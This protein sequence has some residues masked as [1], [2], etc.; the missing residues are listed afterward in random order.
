MLKLCTKVSL[1]TNFGFL[2]HTQNPIRSPL[3]IQK[4][5]TTTVNHWHK[6][7]LHLITQLFSITASRS[8][9]M[10][11]SRWPLIE[12]GNERKAKPGKGKSKGS[13]DDDDDDGP[14]IEIDLEDIKRQCNIPL[15][16]LRKEYEGIRVTRISPS[17]D[18]NYS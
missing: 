8:I 12:K 15:D 4:A 6:Q 13:K 14:Q 2:K 11:R 16:A 18:C 7:T 1:T 3:R 5:T 17:K 9:V 10:H